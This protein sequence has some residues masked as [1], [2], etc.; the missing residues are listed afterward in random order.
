MCVCALLLL[1][2]H[3]T[4][5]GRTATS[6]RI[7]HSNCLL[8]AGS[9]ETICCKTYCLLSKV[10]FFAFSY[11][12][13]LVFCDFHILLI[14]YAHKRSGRWLAAWGCVARQMFLYKLNCLVN[15]LNTRVISRDFSS[16]GRMP[17][18]S[19]TLWRSHHSHI[20]GGSP[21]HFMP[22][23]T[24]PYAH[25]LTYTG[26]LFKLSLRL[27]SYY[28]FDYNCKLI[29]CAW[30]QNNVCASQFPPRSSRYLARN[31]DNPSRSY[32]W[33]PNSSSREVPLRLDT[34]VSKMTFV[35]FVAASCSSFLSF[36]HVHVWVFLLLCVP[37]SRVSCLLYRA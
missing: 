11:F 1:S 28:R 13:F 16:A 27:A 33:F 37:S 6:A 30:P 9:V 35:G 15:S 24:V 22:I 2:V 4:V 7:L 23:L 20:Y 18:V 5:V 14:L 25:A 32:L 36:L 26:M 31:A 8:H 19:G 29:N 10:V 17:K 3:L 21:H 34:L 12:F